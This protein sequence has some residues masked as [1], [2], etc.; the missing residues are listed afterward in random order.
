MNIDPVQ[1]YNISMHGIGWNSFK[2]RAKKGAKKVVQFILDSAPSYTAESSEKLTN[3]RAHIN[4]IISRPMENRLINGGFALLTQPIIDY[5]NHRVDDETREVA[6][7]R[8]VAKIIA[9]TAAGCAVRG[10]V[11]KLVD[12]MTNPEGKTRFSKLLLPKRYIQE[13]IDDKVRLTNY[14]K[15]YRNGLSMLLALCVM[16]ITNFVIDAP[17]TTF[18]TNFFNKTRKKYKGIEDNS[19]LQKTMSAEQNFSHDPQSN[20]VKMREVGYA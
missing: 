8:T 19:T 9:C 14:R 1:D 4:D 16:S 13:M 20:G 10:P 7:C 5:N 15:S 11:Y 12:L 2:D 17:L 6:T 3:Q 18:L